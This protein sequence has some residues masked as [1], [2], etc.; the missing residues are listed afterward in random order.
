VTPSNV[1]R[2]ARTKLIVASV[3]C[4]LGGAA[5]WIFARYA[6]DRVFGTVFL[7]L[8]ALGLLAHKLRPPMELTILPDGL[9]VRGQTVKWADVHVGE[10]K[11][12]RRGSMRYPVFELMVKDASSETGRRTIDVEQPQWPRFDELYDAL[13]ESVRGR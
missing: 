5:L 13:R 1:Y 4:L 9:V 6:I 10:L 3:G 8:G 2:A 12:R 11:E 7:A